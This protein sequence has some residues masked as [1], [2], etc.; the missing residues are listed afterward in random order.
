[1]V[2]PN[3]L[4]SSIAWLARDAKFILFAWAV[5]LMASIGCAPM[6]PA[7]AAVEPEQP[8]RTSA[9]IFDVKTTFYKSTR[10][11]D[12]IFGKPT[13]SNKIKANSSTKGMTPGEYREYTWGPEKK[14]V[15]ARFLKGKCVMI[16]LELPES[17]DNAV[18][19]VKS[20]GI[21]PSPVLPMTVAPMATRWKAKLGM[22]IF[23]DVAAIKSTSPEGKFDMV[24]F[25]LADPD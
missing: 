19:A 7:R 9:S 12:A 20:V 21:D 13:G 5:S 25:E 24:Q 16:Q 6:E 8:T 11:V 17:F 3:R 18:E 22:F 1:M 23:K 15:L 2:D 4:R 14:I 10:V